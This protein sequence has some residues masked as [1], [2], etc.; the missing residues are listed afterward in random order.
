MVKEP[1]GSAMKRIW[2]AVNGGARQHGADLIHTPLLPVGSR[3]SP[4]AFILLGLVSTRSLKIRPKDRASHERVVD[5][6]NKDLAGRR[7]LGVRNE[8]GDMGCRARRALL[9]GQQA[10]MQHRRK[11]T[12]GV[13][14]YAAGTP[15]IWGG[16]ERSAQA[17]VG[18]ARR[19]T[20]ESLA[21]QLLGDTDL[22]A[23]AGFHELDVRHGVAHAHGGAGRG[24]EGAL[25]RA[26]EAREGGGNTAGKHCDERGRWRR[27]CA[28]RTKLRAEG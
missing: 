18:T 26:R 3:T 2:D 22:V 14:L 7:E 19:T 23:G 11:S 4:H 1:A 10:D 20:H 25:G 24:V 21:F 6:D 28:A 17:R 16:M 8:A 13:S 12:L 27:C 9:A 5:R 15:M